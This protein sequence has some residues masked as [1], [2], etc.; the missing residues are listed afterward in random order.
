MKRFISLT[1]LPA[2][3][4]GSVL[5]LSFMPA[6]ADPGDVDD[7]PPGLFELG[8]NE[9]TLEDT[10][11]LITKGPNSGT[12][13]PRANILGCMGAD[14]ENPAVD[15]CG[16][17]SVDRGTDTSPLGNGPDWADLFTGEMYVN[18][19]LAETPYYYVVPSFKDAV[20]LNGGYIETGSNSFED[21]I[22]YGGLVAVFVG[23]DISAGNAVDDTTMVSDG[24]DSNDDLI[25]TYAWGTDSVPSKDDITNTYCY[26]T[27]HT[28]L[29]EDLMIYC[30]V[31][32]LSNDGS[33]HVD[34]ELNKNYVGLDEDPPCDKD[35]CWMV[36]DR[37]EG[38]LLVSLDFT[39]GGDFGSLEIRRWNDDEE[40][41]GGQTWGDPVVELDS[42]GCNDE[43]INGITIP[44]GAACA[45]NNNDFINGGPWPNFIK[46]V[47]PIDTDPS[48]ENG[49][50]PRNAFS[51]FG[52]NVSEILG[53]N[54]C[55]S[56]IQVKTRTS[57]SFT[58]QLKDF[59]VRPFPICGSTIR[60]EIRNADG[61]A[62]LTGQTVKVG[63]DI[64]DWAEVST[65]GPG[66]TDDP[67]GVVD[68][69]LYPNGTCSGPSSAEDLGNVLAGGTPDDNLATAQTDI[70][71]DLGPGTWSFHADFISD[72]DDF[73]S[74]SLLPEHCEV[75]TIEQYE[76]FI[77]TQ[78]HESG[79]HSPDIQGDT[80]YVGLT[81]HDHAYLTLNP[82]FSAAP[83][84]TGNVDFKLYSTID[85]SGEFTSLSGAID[86]NWEAVT[87]DNIPAGDTVLSYSASYAGDTFFKA[88]VDEICEPLEIIKYDSALRTEIHAGSTHGADLQGSQQAVLTSVHDHAYWWETTGASSL[89]APTGDVTFQLFANLTCAGTPQSSY[90]GINWENATDSLT[91]MG[92]P[93]P[94]PPGGTYDAMTAVFTP[95]FGP[96]S[97]KATWAE[98]ANYHG[99]EA[100]CESLEIYKLNPTVVTK[101][102]V[103]DLAQVSGSG[104]V[105][106]GTVTFKTYRT[107]DCTG[108]FESEVV[109]LTDGGAEQ[110]TTPEQVLE[111]GA[112]VASYLAEYSGDPV[113][114]GKIHDCEVVTF[115]HYIPTP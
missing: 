61:N 13:D 3:L 32:R 75:I 82:A 73:P 104:P 98:D 76:P 91:Q 64:Y 77:S 9:D 111:I 23:D 89:P 21:F 43:I 19:P 110:V 67:T 99:S 39:N 94:D 8:L 42:E 44:A 101:V 74:T 27:T 56:Y 34:I 112:D 96:M 15:V 28:N 97:I 2:I 106:T 38:D 90:G 53:A 33:S 45:F 103:H 108:E 35:V 31:E 12:L 114:E 40:A 81:I 52:L 25:D 11:I 48:F 69:Y 92:V 84:P 115:S 46:D 100:A 57:H 107:N 22:D 66:I 83:Q 62:D 105:P 68:F 78:I 95:P 70:F 87:A 16:N 55:I 29:G 14:A 51:E 59:A 37:A 79:G 10:D 102:K 85:C 86:S 5:S 36:G 113:Y 93:L 63:T 41:N 58:S 30:G 20:Q 17:W 88:T 4:L 71:Y 6:F 7:N 72:N 109:T 18:D 47:V 60:T 24:S 54:Q 26:A 80:V 65:T 49:M 1:T 50:L